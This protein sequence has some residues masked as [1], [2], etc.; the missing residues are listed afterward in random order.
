[1]ICVCLFKIFWKDIKSCNALLI[2][3]C[4]LYRN[5]V[6][7][8]L[9][10]ISFCW[11][12]FWTALQTIEKNCL[13]SISQWT[14]WTSLIWGMWYVF[15]WDFYC[16]LA[17]IQIDMLCIDYFS[18]GCFHEQGVH[19]TYRYLCFFNQIGLICDDILHAKISRVTV[20]RKYSRK[21]KL[22]KINI[23]W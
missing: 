13:Y 3:F 15:Q 16:N 23:K 1:M 22:I 9:A 5:A 11:I 21:Q 14:E 6:G 2:Y 17:Y 19:R 4:I 10:R 12:L 20:Y 8:R 18:R 7:K